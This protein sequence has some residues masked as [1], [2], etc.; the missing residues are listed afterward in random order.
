M[1]FYYLQPG[2]VVP[3]NTIATVL[4][5]LTK[6]PRVPAIDWGVIVRRCM[7]VEALIPHKSTNHRDPTL[8]RE[9]CLY[10]SLAHADHISPLLQFLD[11]LTDLPRFRR[12]E[13]NVQSVLL[14]YLSHLMKLFSDSRSKKLYDDLAV[15]FCSHSSSYLDY[16]SEQRSMLR[17]SFW[18]GICKCLVEVVSEETDSFSY[19]KK[20]IECLLPLL[21]LCNDGQPELVDEWSAAI[22]CLIVAQ[23]SWPGD[24]LQVLF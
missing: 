6:A 22:K 15:Y 5:C 1:L 18:K 24:M 20:C 12:L 7:K 13:M 10:F 2:D 11:D 16:S 4:K 19:V 17:M 9:E 14:Q 23:K 8:L 21:N 3:V